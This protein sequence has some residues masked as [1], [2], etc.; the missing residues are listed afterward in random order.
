M[1]GIAQKHTQSAFQ[2]DRSN[3]SHFGTSPKSSKEYPALPQRHRWLGCAAC[4]SC[5]RPAAWLSRSPP[6]WGAW[7]AAWLLQQRSTSRCARAR[8]AASRR[9]LEKTGARGVKV[10]MASTR[11]NIKFHDASCR[12]SE[13]V[14]PRRYPPRSRR[15]RRRSPTP[16]RSPTGGNSPRMAHVTLRITT[17]RKHSPWHDQASR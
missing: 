11:A 15:T 16:Q 5:L 8:P 7:Y 3:T 9:C 13:A 17:W 10:A 14:I 6:T 4:A 12:R 2:H 1:R